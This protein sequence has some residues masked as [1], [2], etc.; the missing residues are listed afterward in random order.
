M[1]R[2]WRKFWLSLHGWLGLTLGGLLVVL[3]LTGSLL[4]FYT[5]I[6]L[7]LNPALVASQGK[8]G[9]PVRWSEAAARLSRH[10]PDDAGGWRIEAPMSE[11]HPLMARYMKPPERAGRS[12]APLIVTLD[13]A[14][15]ALTSSRF[16][17]DFAVTWIYDLHYTLLWGK[18][19]RQVIGWLAVVA[20]VFLLSGL[21]LW[22]PARGKGWPAMRPSLRGGRILLVYDLHAKAGFYGLLVLFALFLTGAVLALPDLARPLILGEQPGSVAWESMPLPG[23]TMIVPDRAAQ[24]AQAVFPQGH[25]RWLETPAGASGVYRVSLWQPGEPGERFPRTTVWLDAWSGA[26]LAVRDPLQESAG[27]RF[28]DW[29]HPLHNGEAFGLAG[30]ILACVGGLL[31]LLLFVTG[32]VRWMDRRRARRESAQRRRQTCQRSRPENTAI[33]S[34]TAASSIR[35]K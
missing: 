27:N 8:V 34:S 33:E 18:E 4:V 32:G 12:F 14:S 5:E 29:M 25:L 13:P 2:S 11:R 20:L 28:L 19:G 9:Q 10:R 16:W 22:W 3:G 30:R 15:L 21:I 6:D 24:L 26:V 1:R 17:G 23:A 7:W 31:P 35:S